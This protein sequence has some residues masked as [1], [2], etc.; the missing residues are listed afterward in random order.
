MRVPMPTKSLVD[1]LLAAAMKPTEAV[2]SRRP[3]LDLPKD[4]AESL[5]AATTRAGGELFVPLDK[6]VA[7]VGLPDTY[8]QPKRALL[9]AGAL[10]RRFERQFGMKDFRVG[11]V[12]RGAVIRLRV[13][14]RPRSALA[15]VKTEPHYKAR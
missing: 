15:G 8:N 1:N 10:Q 6:F 9:L 12:K 2:M 11:A 4:I 7:L 13:V 3:D 14:G 5:R